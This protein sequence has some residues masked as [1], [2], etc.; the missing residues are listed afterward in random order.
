MGKMAG[1]NFSKRE[2]AAKLAGCRAEDLINFRE[3]VEGG[4]IAVAPDGRK[5]RFSALELEFIEAKLTETAT[6]KKGKN[7]KEQTSEIKKQISDVTHFVNR[8]A[9]H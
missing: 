8:Q 2:L 9:V 7:K 5:L 4:I 3:T 1:K 6:V